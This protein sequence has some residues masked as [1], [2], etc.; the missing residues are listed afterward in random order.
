[1]KARK[2]YIFENCF[3]TSR[4]EIKKEYSPN[5]A[6]VYKNQVVSFKFDSYK[7]RYIF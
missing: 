6:G 7:I 3:P 4:D 1:M 2:Q 5:E